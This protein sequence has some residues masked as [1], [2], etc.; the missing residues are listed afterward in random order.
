MLL[1]F[2]AAVSIVGEQLPESLREFL[3]RP[4]PAL[5]LLGVHAFIHV[6]GITRVVLYHA[7]Q[8]ALV[9][10]IGLVSGNVSPVI[11]LTAWMCGETVAMG[12]SRRMRLVGTAWHA[13]AG[14]LIVALIAGADAA[15][16]WVLA[17]VPTIAFVIVI[18]VLY[19]RES[20]ARESAQELAR[21]LADSNRRIA[22]YAE[23]A[24][25]RSRA[26]ERQR[27]ARDL[28]DTLAQGLT[29]VILQIRAAGA[30]LDGGR[31]ERAKSILT[32]SL[33]QAQQTLS[34]ARL[35]IEDLRE[36]DALDG[37]GTSGTIHE[38]FQA[39]CSDLSSRHALPVRLVDDR[40]KTGD[41][42]LPASTVFELSGILT[43]AVHNAVRHGACDAVEV[44]VRTLGASVHL[45]IADNGT[46][47]DP[48]RVP[49]TGHYGI[50]GMRERAE[51]L[52]G[53]LSI[54][55]SRGGGTTVSVD[56]PLERANHREDR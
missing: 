3:F 48:S 50:R 42:A 22:E 25:F 12:E 49:E 52:G 9:A 51:S 34:E 20:R 33:E 21:E 56:V 30:H 7:V 26:E 11:T 46:G 17:A 35:A 2:I 47:F 10:A 54:R 39:V 40:E 29:G 27:M 44:R 13:I 31:S 55:S 45:E 38:S 36:A 41:I 15:L 14:L 8:S 18:I 24:A 43:E 32:D 16:Q 23:Q 53:A 28:H 1:L 37:I 4:V 6:R 5:L 19:A